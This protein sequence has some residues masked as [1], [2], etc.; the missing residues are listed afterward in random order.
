M[1]SPQL[2]FLSLIGSLV[3]LGC[4]GSTGNGEAR[5]HSDA[6]GVDTLAGDVRLLDRSDAKVASR[7]GS[8]GTATVRA[9]KNTSTSQPSDACRSVSEC[10]TSTVRCCIGD[11]WGPSGCPLPPSHCPGGDRIGVFECTTNKDCKTGGT[12][13]SRI[14]GCPQ[15]EY[16]ECV[17]PP[18][19]CTPSPDNCAPDGRCQADGKCAPILCTDGY[20]CLAT[21]RCKVGGARA[22][23]HGCQ[24]IP[25]DDGWTCD[26]NARCT[27]PAD[28]IGHGCMTLACSTDRDCDCGYCLNGSCSANLGACSPEPQ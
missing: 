1:T 19:A 8:S 7:D 13:V 9:C 5:S 28:P 6:S 2:S 12:C 23:G 26:E 3:L 18:P 4:S 16:R 10:H 14:W 27:T 17:Y 25:C 20:A 11:C 21:T 24:P 22:D 15:C